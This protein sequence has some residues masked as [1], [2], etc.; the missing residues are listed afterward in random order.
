MVSP[1]HGPPP[2]PLLPPPASPSH[3]PCHSSGSRAETKPVGDARSDLL[4]AIR[5]G[6][7]VSCDQVIDL[8][9]VLVS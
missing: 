4:A 5:V 1:P 7:L 3:L 8:K 6:E 9:H 2:P